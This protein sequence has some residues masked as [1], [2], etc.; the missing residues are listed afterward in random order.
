MRPKVKN[1]TTP[2]IPPA[3]KR[4]SM[5]NGKNAMRHMRYRTEPIFDPPLS[6]P[7]K[8]ARQNGDPDRL[9]VI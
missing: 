7:E 5:A 8:Y 2:L 3:I 6:E 9:P 1:V 4:H